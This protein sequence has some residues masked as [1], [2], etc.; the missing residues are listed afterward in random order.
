MTKLRKMIGVAFVAMGLLT[1]LAVNTAHAQ[2]SQGR[3]P[4]ICQVD[5]RVCDG[6][7]LQFEQ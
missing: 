3:G 7:I 1:G 2:L 5:P 4:D 6:V